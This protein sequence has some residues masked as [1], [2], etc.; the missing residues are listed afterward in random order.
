MDDDHFL[1]PGQHR[2]LSGVE[3]FDGDGVAEVYPAT[4]RPLGARCRCTRSGYFAHVYSLRSACIGSTFAARRDGRYAARS[5]A[6]PSTMVVTISSA[7]FQ[8]F[9]PTSSLA[10]KEPAP[11]VAGI[12]MTRPAIT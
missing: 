8:G 1:D 9:T 6:I 7:G 11:T 5:P 12:P 3:I 2:A 10:M 4:S